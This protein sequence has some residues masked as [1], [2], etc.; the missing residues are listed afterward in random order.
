MMGNLLY[1]DGDDLYDGDDDFDGHQYF[2]EGDKDDKDDK[3]QFWRHLLQTQ[4]LLQTF[5]QQLE[6]AT[7][8][9]PNQN[10]FG[11]QQK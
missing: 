9:S 1:E 4:D 11:E 8:W 3:E 7:S 2:Y 6:E 10:C 5:V